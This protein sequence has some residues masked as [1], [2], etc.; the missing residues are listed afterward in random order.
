MAPD[1]TPQPTD[2]TRRTST[3]RD[4]LRLDVVL[5]GRDG[6]T[7]VLMLHG[8]PQSARS[9]RAVAGHLADEDLLLVAPDQRG[10]SPGARPADVAAYGIEELVADALAVADDLGLGRF[11]LV[12]HDW[13]SSVAWVLAAR[14][15][16]RVLTLTAL[17]VPHL[18][19]FGRALATDPEQQ[20]L[21]SYI[22]R[23]RRPGEAEEVLL[24]DDAAGLRAI[25][26]GAVPAEDVE[27]YVALM[28]GGALTPALSWYRAMGADLGGTPPV[29]VPT[30]FV[31]GEQDRATAEAAALGCGAFVEADYRFV[32]LPEVGHWSPDQVPGVVAEEVRARVRGVAPGRDRDEED[33]PG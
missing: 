3:T 23:F 32:R 14:H 9:W 22:K 2:R 7:P 4:G 8:F 13:G 31:W 10:Y 30:T 27:A 25:Y 12:G 21:S 29:R 5:H 28:R 15:P 19:A 11:H 20:R 26:D 16:E 24:A 18:A 6:A 1:P 17:S 33:R